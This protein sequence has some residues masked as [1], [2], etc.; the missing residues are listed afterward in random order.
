MRTG[1]PIQT[2]TIIF[3]AEEGLSIGGEKEQVQTKKLAKPQLAEPP[4]QVG[5][6]IA[7]TV[8]GLGT[9]GEGVA[10]WTEE[11]ATARPAAE[12]PPAFTVFVEGAIPGDQVQAKIVEV[13]RNYARGRVVELLQPSP[14]RVIPR[15][16]VYAECGG[17][18]LQEMEY[19]EQLR[20]KMRFVADAL[21]RIG[22]LK[23]FELRETLAAE[24]PWFYRNKAI[25]PVGRSPSPP[26]AFSQSA[27]LPRPFD[28]TFRL[29][30]PQLAVTRRRANA[31]R[32]VAGLYARGTHR[33]IDLSTCPI[34]HPTNN[35]ILAVTK[36][37]LGR[38]GYPPYDESSGQGLIRHLMARTAKATG[39]AMVGLVINGTALPAGKKFAA[40]LRRRLPAVKSVVLNINRQRTNVI[41]G[42]RTVLLDGEEAIEDRLGDLTFRLSARSFFQVNPEQAEA[43]YRRAREYSRLTGKELVIDAFTGT[44]TIA[45]FLAGE[46]GQV[47]GIEEIPEAVAD[48]RENARRNG[49]TNVDFRQG[50]VEE[51]LPALAGGGLHPE[52]VVLDPPR[53]GV[54]EKA[55][56]AIAQL[57]PERIVYVSCNPATLARDLAYLVREGY[58]VEE[59]QPVDMFPQTAHV[60]A[61]AL[62][63]RDKSGVAMI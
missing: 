18:Q 20:W 3:L 15:C 23:D 49:I 2:A 5:Q 26:A 36:E 35:E 10:R 6:K 37:L 4:L 52:V 13:K 40:D 46:A 56:A 55:L 21:T 45:L 1:L 44:G 7:L 60:E 62:V 9:H 8:E 11:G 32:L 47:I 42:E 17:C 41:F 53:R 14:H 48:A 39:Q 12:V 33:I 29:A 57:E 27:S 25:F 24:N 59:V 54:E 58:R 28:G 31:E 43:L 30:D 34:Q 22:G 63:V 50:K 38:Y 51:V 16:P 61:V 19:P